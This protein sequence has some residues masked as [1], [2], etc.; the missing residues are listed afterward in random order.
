MADGRENKQINAFNV[1]NGTSHSNA[2]AVAED[3]IDVDS[4]GSCSPM[5]F[6]LADDGPVTLSTI[7]DDVGV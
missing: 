5:D 6:A 1:F 7:L 4:I 2:H 3:I